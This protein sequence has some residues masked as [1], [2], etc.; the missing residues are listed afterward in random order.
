MERSCSSSWTLEKVTR[1]NRESRHQTVISHT[2]ES[3]T[4]VRNRSNSTTSSFRLDPELILPVVQVDEGAIKHVLQ[5]ANVMAPGLVPSF[6]APE[7]AA[8]TLPMQSAVA[9]GA[10]GKVHA[11]AI[12][13]TNRSVANIR[14]NM[15]G[16]AITNV[17]SLGDGLWRTSI[18][19]PPA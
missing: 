3:C 16:H 19:L 8:G 14:E 18:S 12:G 9:I 11:F 6:L 13:Y 1:R 5:G 7:S 2:C 15:T 17:H 4:N 10:V